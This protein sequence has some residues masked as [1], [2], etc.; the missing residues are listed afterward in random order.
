MLLGNNIFLIMLIAAKISMKKHWE[1]KRDRFFFFTILKNPLD[2]K[3]YFDYGHIL[4]RLKKRKAAKQLF[5]SAIEIEP[6]KFWG[7][8]GLGQ[9][10]IKNKDIS[11][12]EEYLTKALKTAQ[13]LEI[14]QPNKYHREL[15]LLKDD[16]RKLKRKKLKMTLNQQP[17]IDLFGF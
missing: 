7:N 13:K 3:N 9:L 8:W 12:A 16:L 17:Q 10:L 2:S 1:S 14:Q 5:N 15:F 6:E 4:I 11:D